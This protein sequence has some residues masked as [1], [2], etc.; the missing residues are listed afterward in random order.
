MRRDDERERA[1]FRAAGLDADAPDL[2]LIDDEE[3]ELDERE[4]AR[5]R[6]AAERHLRAR[7]RLQRRPHKGDIWEQLMGA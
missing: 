6:R 1:A 2:S 3:M 4:E 7:D 5:A